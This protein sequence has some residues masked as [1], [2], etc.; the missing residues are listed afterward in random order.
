MTT[1]DR[2][3]PGHVPALC[4]RCTRWLAG[5]PEHPQPCAVLRWEDSKH[6]KPTLARGP[7]GKPTCSDH[8][9]ATTTEIVQEVTA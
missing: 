8:V 9:P 4:G 2:L 5:M 7:D 1:T 6:I 3:I